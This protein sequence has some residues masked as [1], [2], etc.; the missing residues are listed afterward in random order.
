VDEDETCDGPPAASILRL[1][2][3][4]RPSTERGLSHSGRWPPSTA[5]TDDLLRRA[6]GVMVGEAPDVRCGS[7]KVATALVNRVYRCSAP[8]PD[9]WMA[10]I[11]RGGQVGETVGLLV[12]ATEAAPYA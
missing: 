5:G 8:E 1:P 9:D 11:T 12:R 4:S 10:A 7:G 2:W 6:S 3:A